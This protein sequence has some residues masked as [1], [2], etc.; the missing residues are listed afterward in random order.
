MHAG[1]RMLTD[2]D[3]QATGPSQINL[4]DLEGHVPAHPSEREISDSEGDASNVETKKRMHSVY[5]HFPK[6]QNCGI[7]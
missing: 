4:E 1:K 2:H 7:C 6:D 5:T 3:K